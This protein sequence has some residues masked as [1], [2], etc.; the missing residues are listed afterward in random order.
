MAACRVSLYVYDQAYILWIVSL[1][2]DDH[3]D[4]IHGRAQ[5]V[6]AFFFFLIGLPDRRYY[7]L[8]WS[9]E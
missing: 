9:W 8:G 6:L 2:R 3:T 7:R 1:I 5:W 4:C